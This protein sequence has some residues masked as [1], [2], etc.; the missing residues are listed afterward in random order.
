VLLGA[1]VEERGRHG[2]PVTLIPLETL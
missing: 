1:V 2:S